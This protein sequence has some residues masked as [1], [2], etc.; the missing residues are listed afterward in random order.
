V[1]LEGGKLGKQF[2]YADRAGIRFVLVQ[3]ESELANGTVTVKDMRRNAQFE[4]ARAELVKTLRVEWEQEAA[5][6]GG[7]A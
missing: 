2:K 4:V 7:N 6:A 5:M 1:A 3:G